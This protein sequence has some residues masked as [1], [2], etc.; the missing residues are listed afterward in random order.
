MMHSNKQQCEQREMNRA[1]CEVFTGGDDE[2]R[3][4]R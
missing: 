3:H 4:E 2:L 1:S